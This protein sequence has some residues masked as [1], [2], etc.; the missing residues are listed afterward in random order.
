[1]LEKRLPPGNLHLTMHLVNP[2]HPQKEMLPS[3]WPS[4]SRATL[5][6]LAHFIR[7]HGSRITVDAWTYDHIPCVHG[8]MIDNHELFVGYYRWVD[9]QLVGAQCPYRHYIREPATEDHF[10]VFESWLNAPSARRVD[11]P[12]VS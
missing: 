12:A 5:E 10:E 4:A 7:R 11:L 8:F 9:S 1:V 3:H 6:R 2:D